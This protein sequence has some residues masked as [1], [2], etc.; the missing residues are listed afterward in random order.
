MKRNTLISFAVLCT[1]AIYA[2]GIINNGAHIVL[3]GATYITTMNAAGN[4]LSQ[5]GGIIDNT[6]PGATMYIAGNWTNNSA[7]NGFSNDGAGVALYGGTQNIGGSTPTIFYTVYCIN[8]GNK[9]LNVN[10]SIGGQN[11]YNG[12][13]VLGVNIHPLDLN[14][15]RL[16]ITNPLPSAISVANGYIISET[17]TALNPSIVRWH[18]GTNTGSYSI[19]FGVA[20]SQLPFGFNITAGMPAAADYVDVSTRATATS[21]NTPWASGVTHMFDP[22]L[23]Q[24]GS[25]EAVIDRWWELNFT[26]AATADLSLAYRGAENTLQVPYN[27]GNLGVQWWATGWFP[28]NSNIGSTPAV[29]AGIGTVN[30]SAITFAAGT[31]KP[32]VLSSVNAPLPIQLTSFK[33]YCGNG[34]EQLIWT[35]ASEN[36]NDFFTIERS[37]DGVTFR[38]IG[39]VN[40]NGT[41]MQMHQYTFTDP[42]AVLASTYYRLRQT[43]Y[44]G[45]STTAPLILAEN[46]GTANDYIDAFASGSGIHV[47]IEGPAQ[48]YTIAVLDAQGKL[49]MDENVS[50][51]SGSNQFLLQTQQLA[52]GVYLVRVTGNDG[53]T[54]GKKVYLSGE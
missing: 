27:T 30:A 45:Q 20:G 40:G 37:D 28:D 34:K 7:N 15:Y 19:P 44:N 29:T 22:T 12:Q 2:Q 49:V 53:T 1:S 14:G 3:N 31:Y 51:V 18:V 46:C 8:A 50:G 9:V 16:D 39:T 38:D 48:H 10:T 36:N 47:N 43:D 33:A 52:T 13:L 5:N 32:I 23:L 54:F 41:T 25:D 26:S 21:A 24:D 17:N 6:A 42:Q 11:L 35:T 4:Y